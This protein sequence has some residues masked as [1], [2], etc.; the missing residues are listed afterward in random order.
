M[1]AAWETALSTAID[2]HG[3]LRG[4]HTMLYPRTVGLF[5][6]ASAEWLVFFE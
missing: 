1:D 4:A 2:G 3:E 6:P 5:D